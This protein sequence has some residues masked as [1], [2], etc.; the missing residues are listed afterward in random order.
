MILNNYVI[1]TK[2]DNPT[3]HII[4]TPGQ[5]Y[6]FYAQ[7]CSYL[8]ETNRYYCKSLH[9]IPGNIC[10]MYMIQGCLSDI[11]LPHYPS[12]VKPNM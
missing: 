11:P 4:L 3:S 5:K 6:Y 8:K 2:L 9:G 10:L 1:D 12:A 7:N